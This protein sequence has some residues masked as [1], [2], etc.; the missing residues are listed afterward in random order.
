[1]DREI[2]AVQR[3]QDYI[4]EHLTEDIT[5]KELSEVALYS[6]WYSY[7]IFVKHTNHSLTAN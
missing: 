1:M 5:L 6:P 7:R 4:K 3:M 2:E